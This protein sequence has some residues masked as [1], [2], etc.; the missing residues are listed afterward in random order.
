MDIPSKVLDPLWASLEQWDDNRVIH[1]D[2]LELLL[3]FMLSAPSLA[4]N[5]HQTWRGFQCR[6]RDGQT[7]LTVKLTEGPTPLVGFVTA[8]DP[9]SSVC[10]FMS[11]WQND[12][13]R[14]ARDK[15]PWI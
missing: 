13:V 6:Q 5:L 1:V 8:P 15:Y 11:L 3:L 4:L 9:L 14:W 7:L 12:R 10:R 2:D